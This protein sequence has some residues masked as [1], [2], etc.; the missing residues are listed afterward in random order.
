MKR[1]TK[2][3]RMTGYYFTKEFEKK[4]H[5]KNKVR[6]IKEDTVAKFFLEGDTEVLVYF[7]ESDRE[8]LITPES[9]PEDIK[10]YL[11]EK[12]LNK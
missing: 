1:Y 9:N 12:F 5:H 11:G 3:I 10:R 2:V 4:K 7:W 6:E 8:I